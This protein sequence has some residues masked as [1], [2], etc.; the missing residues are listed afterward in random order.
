[1]KGGREE[2]PPGPKNRYMEDCGKWT[3]ECGDGTDGSGDELKVHQ[4]DLGGNG[5]VSTCLGGVNCA[6]KGTEGPFKN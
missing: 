4:V 6:G 3:K 1:M 2:R 5:S